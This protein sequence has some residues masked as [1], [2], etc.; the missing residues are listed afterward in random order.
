[1]IEVWIPGKPPTATS[2]QKGRTKDGR[3]YKPEKLRAAEEFYLWGLKRIRP[4]APMDGPIRLEVTFFY[5]TNKSHKDGELKI[6]R[7]DNDNAVKALKDCMT[8]MGY[9]H[10]DAQVTTDII[11]KFYSDRPGVLIRVTEDEP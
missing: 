3:W 4:T 10:D 2:Q 1:M 11:R 6:T 7:P 9:W 8:K 5:P